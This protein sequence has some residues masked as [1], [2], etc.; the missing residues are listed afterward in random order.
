MNAL[1]FTIFQVV[2][3]TNFTITNSISIL[4]IH[5]QYQLLLSHHNI[6]PEPE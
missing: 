3:V 2:I 5:I 1:D 4:Y 6:L